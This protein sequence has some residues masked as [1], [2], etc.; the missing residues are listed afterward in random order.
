MRGFWIAATVVLTFAALVLLA[1][2]SFMKKS[3]TLPAS[4]AGEMIVTTALL[5]WTF[6]CLFFGSDISWLY[7]SYL[8][9]LGVAGIAAWGKT[10]PRVVLALAVL[11]L[12]ADRALPREFLGPWKEVGLSP[13]IVGLWTSPAVEKAWRPSALRG[14]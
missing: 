11:G 13:R 7:Y 6:V 5:H 10:G 4:S 8:L 9:V 14:W 3:T 1:V 2:A 12:A